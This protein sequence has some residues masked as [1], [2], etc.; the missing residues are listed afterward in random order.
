MGFMKKCSFFYPLLLSIISLSLQAQQL[1]FVPQNSSTTAS[2]RGLHV[3]NDTLAWASGAKGTLLK[4]VDGGKNWTRLPAPDSIDFRSLWAFN[5]QQAIIAS[6]GQPA[7]IYRTADG[8]NSWQLVYNDLTGKAFFD[9]VTFWNTTNGLAL[10]DPIDGKILL[11]RTTDS[12]KSWIPID[13]PAPK[14]GEAF[15][16]ASN[17]SIAMAGNQHAWIGTGGGAIRV[18]ATKNGGT[19]WKEQPIAMPLF[20]EAAGLYALSFANPT[21]GVAI[22]GA[23][24]KPAD[25]TYTAYYTTNGGQQWQLAATTPKGYR[26]GVA[27]IPNSSAV[28]AVG[29]T[30]TDISRDK[31]KTW[32]P[33]NTY[34][35]N[36]IRFAPGGKRGWAVGANGTIFLIELTP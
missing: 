1:K 24:D 19:T 9:A 7:K 2:L 15:F 13:A 30:G 22:G 3:L 28:V 31:G 23:Y 17:G 29:T 14:A 18:L 12:G 21:A 16:A 20:S 35:L 8:G 34:N 36:S 4:T 33:Q 10:S 25:S 11:L 6:A 26:S 32:H 5:D 27:W